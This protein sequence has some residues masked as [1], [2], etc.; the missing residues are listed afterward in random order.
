MPSWLVAVTL[1]LAAWGL[2]AGFATAVIGRMSRVRLAEA[3]PGPAA[4]EAQQWAASL[5]KVKSIR[6]EAEGG[7]PTLPR[8]GGRP[9]RVLVVD[10]DAKLRMLIRTSFE[11]GDIEV[12]EAEDAT[13]AANLVARWEPDVLVLDVAM[14]GI[15]GV[16]F[17]RQLK[18]DPATKRIAVVLLTGADVSSAEEAG[19]D[20]LLR[21]PFS[22]LTL[23]ATVER[24]GSGNVLGAQQP[25]LA[26]PDD[27]QLLLYAQ[28]FRRL[29]D[30]E[31]GQRRL[32]ESAYRE[33]AVALAHALEAKDGGTGAHSERVRRYATELARAVDPSLLQEP[34]LE[35]GFIL[36]D[37]G[38]IAIPDALLAKRGPLS[39]S[40]R[41]VLESHP[42]L[43]E[44]MVGKAA[45]LRGL[46]A[47]VVRS[48]H[49]RWDGGGYPDKLSG[50][51][52]PLGARIF[53]VADA[54]DA[55]T[56]DRPYRPARGWRDAVNEITRES[57]SQF[58]P[59]IVDLFREREQT[60]R[61]VYYEVSNN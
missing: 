25:V 30:L 5:A 42:V 58:D 46:G 44:Q 15:D 8:L 9:L 12:Q 38:K 1:V 45:L 4:D 37:V 56:S 43:G 53:S 26:H 20:A 2:G 32:L 13:S 6:Q 27:Q 36:H 49:E 51:D 61:R 16:T 31:R 23:L 34:S 40:E 11:A 18:D 21:K 60:M 3:E 14:P 17:C 52:I 54:L 57:G 50:D 35:Y 41:R 59:D 55:M 10:D 29:V 48:H 19:A 33:T 7:F 28:D 24:L 39:P 47:S 22:P